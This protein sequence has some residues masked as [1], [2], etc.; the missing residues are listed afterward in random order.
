M[1]YGERDEKI[2]HI[3]SE[4]DKLAQ[5]EY[6]IRHTWLGKVIHREQMDIHNPERDA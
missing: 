5:R 4:C 6:K 3:M 1:L 2:D